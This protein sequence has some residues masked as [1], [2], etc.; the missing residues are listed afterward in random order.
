MD[1]LEVRKMLFLHIQRFLFLFLLG[2]FAGIF[3]LIIA[4]G[5]GA[6]A[7]GNLLMLSK[8]ILFLGLPHSL[9][10]FLLESRLHEML[11]ARNFKEQSKD[12]LKRVSD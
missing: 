3:L 8:V 11:F 10:T 6:A 9:E 12:R 1:P 4:G 2:V 7:A 5:F